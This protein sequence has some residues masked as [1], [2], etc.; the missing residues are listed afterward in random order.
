MPFASAADIAPRAAWPAPDVEVPRVPQRAIAVIRAIGTATAVAAPIPTG[1]GA[2]D[3]SPA[4]VS[5]SAATPAAL[6]AG[7]A[8]APSATDSD[9][10]ASP[11][12]PPSSATPSTE[13]TGAIASEP[14]VDAPFPSHTAADSTSSAVAVPAPAGPAVG[15]ELA[16]AGA[17]ESASTLP[18]DAPEAFWGSTPARGQG[19]T[20]PGWVL[21]LAPLIAVGAAYA[22]VIGAESIGIALGPLP[23]LAGAGLGVIIALAAALTDPGSLRRRGY[24]EPVSGLWVLLSPLVYLVLRSARVHREGGR[25]WLMVPVHLVAVAGATV[26]ALTMLLPAPGAAVDAAA[27][28][29]Q[30]EAALLADTGVAWTVDCTGGITAGVDGTTVSCAGSDAAGGVAAITG[31]VDPAGG[32]IQ[33]TLT[34]R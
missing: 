4:P 11:A 33:Y 9:A 34:P 16:I 22:A 32:P 19:N 18:S 23:L 26:V 27:A 28:E 1:T 29:T 30:L 17:P 10:P 8:A 12:T 7:R 20:V 6:G 21:A 24:D 31:T 2:A 14:V 13:G 15:T 3:P 5:P 25:S